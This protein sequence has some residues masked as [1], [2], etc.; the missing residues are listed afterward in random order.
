[1]WGKQSQHEITIPNVLK[2]YFKFRTQERS[3]AVL[4]GIRIARAR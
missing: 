3:L 1:M 2:C 4:I